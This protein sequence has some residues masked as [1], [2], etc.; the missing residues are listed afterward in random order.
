[1]ALSSG[2]RK[3][4]AV[5]V[6]I[7]FAATVLFN[8]VRAYRNVVRARIR[9]QEEKT[10]RL[11]AERQARLIPVLEGSTVPTRNGLPILG[12]DGV[13]ADGYTTSYVDQ[14][15]LRSL[16]SS[17]KYFE[18]AGYFEKFQ[19]VFEGDAKHEYW[20]I[21]AAETFAVPDERL[22]PALD[23]WIA[24][25]PDHFAPYLARGA[26]FQARGFAL[27]G[28]KSAKDTPS[29]NMALMIEAFS[30]ASTDL[31]TARNFR[32]KLF[33]AMRYEIRVAAALGPEDRRIGVRSD[34]LDDCPDCF[35]IRATWIMNATPRWAGDYALM[36]NFAK[37]S[38]AA[39]KN[40]RMR[41]LAGYVDNDE[42]DLANIARQPERALPF[43]QKACALGDNPDFLLTRAHT[44]VALQK[45][46]LARVDLDRALAIRPN[47]RSA[48]F[49]RADV[50]LRISWWE[51]AG[52]DLLTGLQIEPTN[53][54]GKLI[55]EPIVQGLVY[56]SSR[57]DKAGRT[58]DAVRVIDLAAELAPGDPKVQQMRAWLLAKSG[59]STKPGEK[60]SVDFDDVESVRR[61]DYALAK[62]GRYE[63]V[64]AL[65]DRYLGRHPNEG[66][67]YL[68][69]GGAY[70]HLR[71]L[72]QAQADAKRAC[73]LGVNE[74]CL[75]ART[76]V[77]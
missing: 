28:T 58:A 8:A 66:R 14:R 10:E 41:F 43:V 6:G 48:R 63:E 36:T 64:V 39:S 12:P 17:G 57:D 49:L 4:V 33:A 50:L 22:E 38:I 27:R 77:P 2:G 74:G 19:G 1:M 40:P 29:E 26:Y 5:G 76:I 24:E 23:A 47:F 70:H 56:Q 69:R 44:Y 65:W 68:E 73:E 55:L 34:A 16:L 13:D 46:D 21:D 53:T 60:P 31:A 9:E 30:R 20:P 61:A 32:P 11:R 75:R 25:M 52:Q 45:F 42:A 7:L 15:A 18:L 54:N 37:T 59:P 72:G 3:L 67:A 62:Q 71:N 35:Q 51:A